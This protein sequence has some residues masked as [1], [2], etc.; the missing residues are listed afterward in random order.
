VRTRAYGAGA[1]DGSLFL[2]SPLGRGPALVLQAEQRTSEALV[3][4]RRL[5]LASRGGCHGAAA[6]G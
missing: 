6:F 5:A 3:P 4:A 2:P 1:L